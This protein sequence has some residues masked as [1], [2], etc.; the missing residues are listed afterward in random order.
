MDQHE[1]TNL[2]PIERRVLAM[3]DDGMQVS[4]IADRMKKSPGFIDRVIEWTAIP[5]EPNERARRFRPIEKRVLDLRAAGQDHS[6]IAQKFK[7]SARFIRQVE[8]MAHYREG[9]RLLSDT[10]TTARQQTRDH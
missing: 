2:R 5:R 6:E 7:K 10:S 3:R 9:L 8:G 1:T 4:E